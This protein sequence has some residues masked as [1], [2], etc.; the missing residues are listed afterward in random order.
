MFFYHCTF[1]DFSSNKE[2]TRKCVVILVFRVVCI[3]SVVICRTINTHTTCVF[4]CLDFLSTI[5]QIITRLVARPFDV[6][7]TPTFRLKQRNDFIS[8]KFLH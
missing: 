7:T 6:G 8:S 4:D 3:I 2:R 1:V 5:G